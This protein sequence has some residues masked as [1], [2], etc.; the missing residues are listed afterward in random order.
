M[1]GGYPEAEFREFKS[2]RWTA[3]NRFKL[4]AGLN[5][6]TLNTISILLE[7]QIGDAA[8]IV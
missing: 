6:E 5:L 3:K 7:S 4:S 2:R 8:Q 1:L